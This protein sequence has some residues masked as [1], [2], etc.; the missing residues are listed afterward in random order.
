MNL[1][2]RVSTG[3]S[4]KEKHSCDVADKILATGN[5]HEKGTFHKVLAL[6]EININNIL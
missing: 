3:W 6:A 1:L 4:D 5:G 2:A